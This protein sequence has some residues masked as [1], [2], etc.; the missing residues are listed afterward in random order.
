VA[1][2][3]C[4]DGATEGT[5]QDRRPTEGFERWALDLTVA[6]FDED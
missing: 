2:G 5:G 3:E 1:D 6:P 4:I